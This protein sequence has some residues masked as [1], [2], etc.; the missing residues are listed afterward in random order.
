[1]TAMTPSDPGYGRDQAL[2][3]A[4]GTGRPADADLEPHTLDVDPN[5]DRHIHFSPGPDDE[6]AV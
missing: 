2:E 4:R 6:P 1:M 3:K 5:P